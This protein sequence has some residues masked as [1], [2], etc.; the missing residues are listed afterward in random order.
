MS[1]IKSENKLV[2]TGKLINPKFKTY[3]NVDVCNGS[4][5]F[6]RK[7]K[8]EF[9]S[10]FITFSAFKNLAKEISNTENKSKIRMVGK[11][12]QNSWIDKDGNKQNKINLDV[13]EF[14]LLEAPKESSNTNADNGNQ[15]PKSVPVENEPDEEVPF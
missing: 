2:L 7:R 8:G 15:Q 3:G 11:I 13:N 6:Y 12:S 4:V 9:V 14:E 10:N 1:E 5:L